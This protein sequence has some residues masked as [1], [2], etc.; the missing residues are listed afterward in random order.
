MGLD[1]NL[2]RVDKGGNP[3]LI[4]ESIK[5]RFQDPQIVDE[6]ISMDKQWRKSYF[7]F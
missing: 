3:E 2:F 1:I 7:L 6:I 5:R 4:K